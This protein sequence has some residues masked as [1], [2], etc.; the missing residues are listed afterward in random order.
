VT[1]PDVLIGVD[2][3]ASTISAG[4]VR[5]SGTVLDTVQ[6]ATYG[7]GSV[8]D[9][10]LASI[11]RVRAQ[12]A[13]RGLPVAGIGVGLPGVVEVEK[14]YLRAMP[15]TPLSD[16]CNVPLASLIHERTGLAVFVDNDVNALSL[17][18]WMFGLGR[19]AASLVTVAIGTGVGGGM[20]V[21]GA[22]VRGR[23]NTA[24][25][26]GHLPVGLTGP[27]CP[28]GAIGCLTAYVGGGTLPERARERLARY[29][30]SA[31]LA[32]AGGD[33]S[34]ID[35]AG[36]FAAAAAGDPLARSVVDEACEALAI[37]IGALVNLLNPEVIVITGGVAASLAPLA[38]DI[39]RRARRRALP[40]VLD[41][42]AVRVAPGD[43]RSTVRGG[44]ALVRYELGRRGQAA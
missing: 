25:E 3:G 19:G 36:L 41:A 21:D 23:L 43:K 1:S 30:G 20:I 22:L 42:T 14:G 34:R 26:I 18:E 7:A 12:A 33:P 11:D 44:A 32:R 8:T 28:C 13:E 24:G 35:A 31:A 6:A 39:L 2:V 38:D 15:A 4:L 27:R 16:L 17:G 29:P 40:E 9:T 5:A 10:I 37:G